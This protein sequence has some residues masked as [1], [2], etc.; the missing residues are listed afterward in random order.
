[1]VSL[2]REYHP[3]LPVQLRI[4]GGPVRLPDAILEVLRDAVSH[5]NATVPAGA[6]PLGYVRL[7]PFLLTIRDVLWLLDYC[8]GHAWALDHVRTETRVAL[9]IAKGG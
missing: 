4:N 3:R 9:G 2:L 7:E 5:R 6:R 1:M 8:R